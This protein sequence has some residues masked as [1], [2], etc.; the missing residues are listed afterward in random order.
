M[1]YG[2]TTDGFIPKTLDI[3]QAEVDAAIK[4]ALGSQVNTLSQSVLGQLK[5][6][7]SERE[8]LL[9]ELLETVYGSQYPSTAEGTS[10]DLVAAIVGLTRF[11]ASYSTVTVAMTGTNGTVVPASTVFSVS[12]NAI[13][14]F[15]TNVGTTIGA[16]PTDIECTAT[17]TGPVAAN[18]GTL[19]IIDN[20]ISGLT[21]VTN[22]E[23]A[24]QGRNIETDTELRIRR[25]QRL[26]ISQA[27]TLEAVRSAI[28]RL[29]DDT[30]LPQVE[31]VALFE[32]IDMDT[33]GRGLQS[34]SFEVI[35]YQSGGMTIRDQEIADAIFAAKPAGIETC[36]TEELTV[37]DSQG[38]GH[39]I[40]FSRPTEVEIYVEFDLTVISDYPINGDT[41]IQNLIVVWGNNLGAGQDVIVYP[42]LIG[43]LIDVPGIIDVV[44]RIGT[45]SD[46]TLDENI[47][48]DDGSVST[49]EISRWDTSRVVVVSSI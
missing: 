49:V 4:T 33:D 45:A 9:W 35:A 10:L 42:A 5:G 46:P 12:G 15:S 14:K 25:N 36:G 31:S 41:Q 37:T 8:T 18:A 22:A 20:P 2:L 6:I 48:I 38:F 34:K 16:T 27:G 7:F 19:T 44:I 17:V 30:S 40:K 28:L 11:A 3:I 13:L 29:N 32:N 26:Q 39:T 23:D 43:Q 24:V 21:S 47:S 1:S